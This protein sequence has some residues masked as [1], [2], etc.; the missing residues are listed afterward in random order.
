MVM[1]RK[2][3]MALFLALMLTTGCGAEETASLAENA[4]ASAGNPARGLTASQVED[5][6]RPI[7][8]EEIRVAYNQAVEAYGWFDLSPLPDD[9]ETCRVDG[10]LYRRVSAPGLE[11][12]EDLR[13][14]LRSLFSSEVTEQLLASGNAQPFYRDIDGVLYVSAAGRIRDIDKGAVEVEVV[15]KDDAA[16][17]VDITVELLDSDAAVAGVECW[18]FPYA[19]VEGRWVFTDFRLVY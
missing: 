16:Y 7:T 12:M 2:S 9:G 13:T 3:C 18:S 5:A 8:E 19:L 6:P 17:S 14:Y 10:V 11:K 1:S 4:G 15:Q